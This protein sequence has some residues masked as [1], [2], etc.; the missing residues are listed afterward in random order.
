M[1]RG[2]ISFGRRENEKMKEAANRGGLFHLRSVTCD[3]KWIERYFPGTGTGAFAPDRRS[4][5]ELP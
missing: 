4:P 1:Y 3:L 2:W 5:G